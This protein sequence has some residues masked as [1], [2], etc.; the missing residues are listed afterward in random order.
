MSLTRKNYYALHCKSMKANHHSAMLWTSCLMV[1]VSS[2]VGP[3]VKSEPLLLRV[4]AYFI[5]SEMDTGDREAKSLN[6]RSAAS[7]LQ[8]STLVWSHKV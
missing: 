2:P 6:L 4:A 5:S 3:M 1:R 8:A 7:L